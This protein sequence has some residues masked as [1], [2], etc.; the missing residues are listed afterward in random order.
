MTDLG[1]AM[2]SEDMV[3]PITNEVSRIE[4]FIVRVRSNAD[5]SV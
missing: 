2:I 1:G 4:L 5:C 3:K